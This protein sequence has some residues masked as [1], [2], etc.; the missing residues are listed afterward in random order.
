M[1]RP[2]TTAQ[3][4]RQQQRLRAQ[5]IGELSGQNK[6]RSYVPGTRAFIWA[7]TATG[8]IHYTH[9]PSGAFQMCGC[10]TLHD[11]I[12]CLID[13]L[14]WDKRY[15]RKYRAMIQHDEG[16]YLLAAAINTLV[17]TAFGKVANPSAYFASM[18][19]KQRW[20]RTKK[21]LIQKGLHQRFELRSEKV[22]DDI[23]AIERKFRAKVDWK[24]HPDACDLWTKAVD[25]DGYGR[26][27]VGGKEVRAHRWWY[28]F[29]HGPI[30]DD[31]D[32]D[33]TCGNR[34]CMKHLAAKPR[35]VNRGRT[36]NPGQG[37][38]QRTR[39][40]NEAMKAKKEGR[41]CVAPMC[42]EDMAGF[43]IVG[44]KLVQVCAEHSRGVT[45]Y[46]FV[47]LED[48][49]PPAEQ[50]ITLGELIA[51]GYAVRYV[52]GRWSENTPSGGLPATVVEN[53]SDLAIPPPGADLPTT[54]VQASA[55]FIS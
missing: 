6:K 14:I 23:T 35:D 15:R 17:R 18:C 36:Q 42:G 44:D 1:V 5:P 40:I 51:D 33:H 38:S 45:K 21:D 25:K 55:V 47:P 27:Y 37:E 39:L 22:F 46:E 31:W 34:R 29:I 4:V 28:Q 53:T 54:P 9:H 32:I 13:M 20:D 43:L 41:G 16:V 49:K 2:R 3:Q 8:E 7:D 30:P 24:D 11:G 12:P 26:H 50:V 52:N 10:D 48:R 19:S